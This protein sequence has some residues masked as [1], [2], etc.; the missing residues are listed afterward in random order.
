MS[1]HIPAQGERGEHG[2]QGRALVLGGGGVT[3]VAWE[4][5]LLAGLAEIGMDLTRADLLVGTSAG[6]VVGAMVASGAPLLTLYE[7]QRAPASKEIAAR[8]GF[9]ALMRWLLILGLPGNRQRARARLGRAALRAKTV[10]EAERRAAIERRLPSAQWPERRLLITAVEA[11]TGAEAV[12]DR[13][14]GVPLVDAVAASCAVPLVWPPITINGR[15]YVDGGVRS[16][17]NV[18]LARGYAKV[19]VLAPLNQ[20]LHRAE[21]ASAQAATLGAGVHSVVISPDV[22]ARKAIGSNVLDPAHR[23]A[24]AEAGHAQAASVAD[25]V[26]A[27]WSS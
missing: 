20:A 3:G 22:A 10:P 4:I 24:A 13:T 12:F 23:A 27:V 7:E 9:G 16:P 26:R 19:V 5:G 6:S 11:E 2:S 14:S 1:A 25:Q 8:L 17:A 18:D 15:H 21:R